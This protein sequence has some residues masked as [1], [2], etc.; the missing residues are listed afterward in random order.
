MSVHRLAALLEDADLT[1]VWEVRDAA[2][3]ALLREADAERR[4]LLWRLINSA[5]EVNRRFT[6]D[7]PR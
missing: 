2:I 1:T 7:Y 6:P 5:M 4:D 3:H